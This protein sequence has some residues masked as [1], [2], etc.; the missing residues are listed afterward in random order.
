VGKGSGRLA[1]TAAGAVFGTLL[2]TQAG[3]GG[4]ARW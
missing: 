4:Y 1:A 2:G 3:Y